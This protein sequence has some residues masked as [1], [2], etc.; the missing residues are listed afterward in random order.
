MNK[1]MIQKDIEDIYP[2]S[3]MQA[4]MMYHTLDE[5]QA[6]AYVEQLRFTLEPLDAARFR[7]AWELMFARFTALRTSIIGMGRKEPVQVARSQV[8]LPWVEH[9]CQALSPTEQRQWIAAYIEQDRVRGFRLDEPSLARLMLVRLAEQRYELIWSL[10][11]IVLDGW[12]GALIQRDLFRTYDALCRGQ[13]ATLPPVPRFR[14]YIAWLRGQNMAAA[15]AYWHRTLQG[16]D[17]PTTIGGQRLHPIHAPVSTYA[18]ESLQLATAFSDA[19]RAGVAVHR[20]TLNTLFQG[21]W[22]LLLARYSHSDDVLF[23]TVVSGRPEALDGINDMVGMLVNT[24]PLR[25]RAPLRQ[26][27]QQWLQELQAS[28]IE[29]RQY[30]YSPLWQIQKW[31][32][33][34]DRVQLFETL[35]VFENIQVPG[36]RPDPASGLNVEFTPPFDRTGYP[37]MLLVV[38]AKEMTLRVT[39]DAAAL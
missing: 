25:V 29:R 27:A 26:S 13:E 18:E 37:L 10:H 19:L 12:S 35:F 38:P 5:P 2:L 39:Y 30:E 4:G 15:E 28:Q 20:V 34:P 14:N 31:S 23:G 16:F 21:A 22:A 8:E 6:G 32:E 33:V 11:H 36:M 1:S 24:L 7:R 3:P 9:D 17:A